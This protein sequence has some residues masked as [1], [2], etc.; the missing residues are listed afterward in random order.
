MIKHVAIIGAGF[1]GTLLAINLLRHEGP[2]ATLIERAPAAGVGLAF[3]AA[4]PEHLLNVR[5]SNMSAMPDEPDHLVKWL[6][7]R[8]VED[9]AGQF[10]PRLL[11]G[12]YLQDLLEEAMRREPGRIEIVRANAVAIGADGHV[13]LSDG[14][15]I[16]ADAAV[17]ALGNLPPHDP[18]GID[19]QALGAD[20]YHSDPWERGLTE[21]LP[22]DG[23]VLVLGTGLTMVDVSLSLVQQGFVGRIVALSRRGLLPHVHET[24]APPPRIAEKPPASAVP[25]LRFVR[26]L[27]HKE[28]WRRAVDALRPITQDL[29]RAS[30]DTERDRFLRHLRAWWDVHRHRLAPQVAAKLAAL[31]Q[32]GGLVVGGARIVRAE[33]R[34]DQ[35]EIVWTPR[36]KRGRETL[37]VDRI[38]NCTGPQGDL[39]RSDEPLLTS[40]IAQGLVRPDD[41]RIGIDVDRQSQVIERD[42]RSSETLF[43]IGPMT[44]GAF[45]EIVAVPDIR[46]QSWELARRLS[47]A[48]WVGGEGL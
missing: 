39:L 44:R 18:P 48:R 20:L 24:T 6:E 37:I 30:S 41:L 9:A 13:E 42:G 46:V 15:T 12:R 32:S 23:K 27:A 3:G 43:A 38:I 1:S 16:A 36:G 33:R 34:G 14:R 25:L 22:L 31:R 47:H 45:W 28:G 8:G 21:G 7:A 35:A 10:I 29:W 5:A 2:R 17:L 40:L 4:H 11:Y 26:A 19:W